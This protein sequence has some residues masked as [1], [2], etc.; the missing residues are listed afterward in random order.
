MS[1][2]DHAECLKAALANLWWL[3]PLLGREAIILRVR[4]IKDGHHRCLREGG[5]EQPA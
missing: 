4:E 5:D 1:K 2:C 3:V